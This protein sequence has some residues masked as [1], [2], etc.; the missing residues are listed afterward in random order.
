MVF[1]NENGETLELADD[2]TLM[3]LTEMGIDI[4]LAEH[5]FKEGEDKWSHSAAH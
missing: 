4:S 5:S 1:K 2:L 3:E